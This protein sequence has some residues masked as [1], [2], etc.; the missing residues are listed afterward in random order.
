VE[1][2]LSVASVKKEDF[3]VDYRIVG[4]NDS[5]KYVHSVGRPVFKPSGEFVEFIGTVM[6]VSERKRTEEE[7]RRLTGQLLQVQD[8]ERRKI[9]KDLHDSTGQNFAAVITLL[10]L[11]RHSMRSCKHQKSQKLLT[12]CEKVAN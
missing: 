9:A 3:A 1:Q 8:E 5:V 7:L 11:I 6:D 4:P 10:D 2:S 12:E